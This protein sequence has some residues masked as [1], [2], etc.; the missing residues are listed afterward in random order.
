MMAAS[1]K[2]N[3]RWA[4]RRAGVYYP[5]FPTCGVR[6]F[7]PAAC[8]GQLLIFEASP[9]VLELDLKLIYPN[10]DVL[11]SRRNPDVKEPW[12]SGLA[13]PTE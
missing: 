4:L 11:Y 6:Y 2:R 10:S 12:G 1:W 13:S 5:E 3:G 7:V 8:Y 9:L